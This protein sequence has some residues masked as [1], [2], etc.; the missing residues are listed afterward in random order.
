[1]KKIKYIF[2]IAGTLVIGSSCRKR[3]FDINNNPNQPSS[4]S[5]DLVL[6]GALNATAGSLVTG[7]EFSNYW[8]GY[9]AVSGG[10]APGITEVSYKFSNSYHQNIWSNFY[11]AINNFNYVEQT[12]SAQQLKFFTGVAKIMKALCYH[13]LVDIYGNIPYS[14][15]LQITKYPLPAYDKAVDIYGSLLKQIDTARILISTSGGDVITPTSDIMFGGDKNQW[16]KFANTLELRLL[17]RMTQISA[18]PSYWSSELAILNADPNGFLGQ[19]Q[20]AAV[21]PGYSN[22]SDA[23]L[24]PFYGTYGYNAVGNTQT[25]L[26]FFRANTYAVNFYQN[27]NDPRLGQFYAPYAGN[28]FAGNDFGIQGQPN[29]V[30]SAIGTGNGLLK[31]PSEGAPVLTSFES[32]F[33]QAEAAQRG[34]IP[35]DYKAL[36]KAAISESFNWFGLSSASAQTYYSQTGLASLQDKVNID[37]SSN[38]LVTIM[39]QK[40]AAINVLNPLE[41]FADYRRLLIP[42]DVPG[43]KYPGVSAQFAPYTTPYRLYYPQSE[44]QTNPDNV[45]AQGNV[46]LNTKIFWMQ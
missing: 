15:A 21:N 11:F 29:N 10:Y 32:L 1:M 39:T 5:V 41:P 19:G 45:S 4:A 13:N 17:L 23:N 44:V 42:A 8:M 34:L 22:A 24:S 16:L 9:W 30:V 38:P 27:T 31:S 3:F 20:S 6:P 35:G 14:Q 12:A 33:L 43:S 25:N 37:L 40:W 2:L 46:N 7:N 28:S 26:G 18:K 36:Y